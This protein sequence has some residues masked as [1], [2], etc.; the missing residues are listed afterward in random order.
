[1]L[2]FRALS[3]SSDSTSHMA[4]S[5]S[6]KSPNF[7]QWFEARCI[8]VSSTPRSSTRTFDSSWGLEQTRLSLPTRGGDSC[9]SSMSCLNWVSSTPPWSWLSCFYGPSVELYDAKSAW[10]STDG[11][12]SRMMRLVPVPPSCCWAGIR[13]RGATVDPLVSRPIPPWN[14]P[15]GG[16]CGE[17]G[18]AGNSEAARRWL[19]CEQ[20]DRPCGGECII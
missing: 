6:E 11:G 15:V 7:Y 18:S 20:M 16:S 2:L 9:S 14:L 17:A 13:M 12:R 4:S 1:M 8:G 3:D 10:A 5:S 19:L